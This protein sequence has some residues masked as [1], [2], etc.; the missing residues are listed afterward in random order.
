M[1]DREIEG[2]LSEIE[3][4]RLIDRKKKKY[5]A[6][7]LGDIEEEIQDKESFKKIRK[8]V[9]DNMNSFTRGVL[10]IIGITIEGSPEN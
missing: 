5:C 4:I 1:K 3:I 2:G 8:T 10:T 9:L 7:L 6:I